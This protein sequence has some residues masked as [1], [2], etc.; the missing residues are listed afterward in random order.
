MFYKNEW[1]E[2]SKGWG[3]RIMWNVAGYF[4]SRPMISLCLGFVNFYIHLPFDTGIQECEPP[5]FG[6]YWYE[7]A[8]WICIGKKIHVFYAPWKF[9]WYR[10]SYMLKDGRWDNYF[11]G[12]KDEIWKDEYKAMLWH[13]NYPYQYTLKSGEVQNRRANVRI[14][15]REWRRRFMMWC[16]LFAFVRTSIWVEFDKEVGEGTGSW[17]GGTLGCGYDLK[18]IGKGNFEEPLTCL[19]R[20]EKERKFSR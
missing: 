2:I 6:F 4:D 15:Q 19:M 17:K 12:N 1:I 9:D 20:M 3:L 14:E 10:T 8:L 18:E 11:K 13:K 7:S 16:P 5:R